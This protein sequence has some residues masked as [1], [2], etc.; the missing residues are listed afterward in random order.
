MHFDLSF[1][2]Q[3]KI[4][5]TT[6]TNDIES[7]TINCILQSSATP[8]PESMKEV[9]K[10]EINFKGV[11]VINMTGQ[12]V[13]GVTEGSFDAEYLITVMIGNNGSLLRGIVFRQ[14]NITPIMAANDVAP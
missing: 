13:Y 14:G 7:L 11:S 3:E 6:T 8:T 5:T 1:Y 12:S 2:L 10:Y 9:E 4:T